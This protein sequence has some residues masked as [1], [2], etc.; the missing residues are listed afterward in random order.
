M[1]NELHGVNALDEDTATGEIADLGECWPAVPEPRR[2]SP[3]S[4]ACG[5]GPG[6]GTVR[7]PHS[8]YLDFV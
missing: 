2:L 8:V 5:R 4:I 3:S 1:I 6:E 7:R